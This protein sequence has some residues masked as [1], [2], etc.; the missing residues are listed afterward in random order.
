MDTNS[1]RFGLTEV[2]VEAAEPESVL[3]DRPDVV[4]LPDVV[5]FA[6]VTVEDVPVVESV[7]TISPPLTLAT[8]EPN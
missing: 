8:F 5:R 1:S 4:A 7:M 6:I 2:V 3:L